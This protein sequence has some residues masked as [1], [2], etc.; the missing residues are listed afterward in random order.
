MTGDTLNLV[1][2]AAGIAASIAVS[3]YYYRLAKKER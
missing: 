2:A 3:F 1:L